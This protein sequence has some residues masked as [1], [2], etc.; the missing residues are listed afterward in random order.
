MKNALGKLAVIAA[1]FPAALAAEEVVTFSLPAPLS[2]FSGG[3][4]VYFH[5]PLAFPVPFRAD[6]APDMVVGS[7]T[8]PNPAYETAVAAQQAALATHQAAIRAYNQNRAARQ[9]A[10]HIL[11]TVYPVQLAAYEADLASY[12]LCRRQTLISCGRRPSRPSR[13][14]IPTALPYPEPP[15][16]PDIS[17]TIDTRHGPILDFLVEGETTLELDFRAS[18]GTIDPSLTYSLD[19]TAPEPAPPGTPQILDVLSILN[20]GDIDGTSPSYRFTM[21]QR[22]RID[23][24]EISAGF[25]GALA[26]CAQ[27]GTAEAEPG[28]GYVEILEITPQGTRFFQ[29][30][31]P[32]RFIRAGLPGIELVVEG[33]IDLD[34]DDTANPF[35]ISV[36]GVSIPPNFT[37]GISTD[38]AEGILE[39]PVLELPGALED[40]IIQGR[41]ESDFVTLN[42]DVD[43]ATT[44]VGGLSIGNDFVSAGADLWDISAGPRLRPYQVME[45]TPDLTLT[46]EFDRPIDTPSQTGVTRWAG[47]PSEV[48]PITVY[49]N[50]T[51]T[52]TWQATAQHNSVM[53]ILF[54]AEIEVELV[55]AE[56]NYLGA[57]TEFGP[58]AP[59]I[60][61]AASQPAEWPVIVDAFQIS[62]FPAHTGPSF[63]MRVEP[64]TAPTGV[65]WE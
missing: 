30:A 53:G 23:R 65:I 33:S 3:P 26:G 61:V 6:V 56:I 27:T 49:E 51:V 18:L 48:P 45:M 52:P 44:L 47:A 22:L 25:C 64:A 28:E 1:F 42:I 8:T 34:A 54:V 15:A 17:P 14:R 13:P 9:A 46:L 39:Y 63:V 21:G 38:V 7:N 2:A 16:P 5:L 41:A 40:G 58:F 55:I 60:P 50:T 24:G 62:D 12:N 11:N 4:G 32:E 31:L 29:H 59:E 43:A 10:Q 19:V 57:T 37:V 20:G 36:N 35:G